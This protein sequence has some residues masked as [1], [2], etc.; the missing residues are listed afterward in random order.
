MVNRSRSLAFVLCLACLVLG[1]GPVGPEVA[2][3]EGTVTLDGKPLAE[4][5]VLFV[6]QSSRPAAAWT[7]KN[8]KYRLMFDEGRAGAVPGESSVRITTA[9][10][11]SEGHP[12][13]KESIAAEYNIRSKLKFTVEPKKKNIANF[14]L[15]SGG[16]VDRGTG[17]DE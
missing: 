16:K 14:D 1:C 3:V 6:N 15:K 7:D 12:G 10:D 13:R 5:S 4:A 11:G 8:G 2:S 17:S 9:R